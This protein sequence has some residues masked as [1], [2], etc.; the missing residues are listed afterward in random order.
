MPAEMALTSSKD[1]YAPLSICRIFSDP[2]TDLVPIIRPY[3]L[4]GVI[5]GKSIMNDK[6]FFFCNDN[7]RRQ[8]CTTKVLSNATGCWR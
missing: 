3:Y 1:S 7:G 5:K 2:L 6:P 8:Y 4:N